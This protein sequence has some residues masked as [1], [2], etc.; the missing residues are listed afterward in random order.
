MR[1]PATF[2][3][4]RLAD[5]RDRHGAVL[6]DYRRASSAVQEAAKNLARLRMEAAT[7]PAAADA[8]SKTGEELRNLTAEQMTNLQISPRTVQQIQAAEARL[9]RLTGERDT[10]RNVVAQSTKFAARLEAFAKER[11]L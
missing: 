9:A 6:A 8:L 11:N 2:D 10:L 5:L 1:S 4:E 3:I 7:H